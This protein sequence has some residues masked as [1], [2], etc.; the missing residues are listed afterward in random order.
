MSE[1]VIHFLQIDKEFQSFK[2]PL[3]PRDYA[4]LEQ[5]LLTNGCT[6]PI[7]TWNNIIID[8]YNRYELCVR[9]SIPFSVLNLCFPCREAALAWLCKNQL[10]R[11]DLPDETR[12]FLIG[13]QCESERAVGTPMVSIDLPPTNDT[14]EPAEKQPKCSNMIIARRIALENDIVYAS[15]IRN[16]AYTRALLEIKKKS[17]LL[18]FVIFSSTLLVTHKD[19][20]ELSHMS[21][22]ELDRAY[23]VLQ[24]TR[25]RHLSYRRLRELLSAD[26]SSTPHSATTVASIKDMP[27]FD[28]DAEITG[29]TLTVPSWTSSIARICTKTN[30]N[31]VS[32]SACG[33]LESVL[34]DLQNQV[35]EMLSAIRRN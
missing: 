31:I 6:D 20:L 8:G 10:L 21:A 17:P 9:H 23:Q 7:V 14:L 11:F 16:I 15:V 3:R 33:R 1:K 29:L 34:I 28:P 25:T 27:A 5:D 26:A 30:L 2:L 12:R 35:F 4:R 32:D 22:A 13:L 19:A 24:K 18:F